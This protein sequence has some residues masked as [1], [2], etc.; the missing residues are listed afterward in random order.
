[1]KYCSC[2]LTC[3]R[4]VSP[5]SVTLFLYIRETAESER[6]PF[7]MVDSSFAELTFSGT[8]K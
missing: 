6:K 2:T 4:Y 7:I 1:M 5:T 8:C 3:R